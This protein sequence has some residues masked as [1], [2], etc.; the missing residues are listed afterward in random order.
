MVIVADTSPINYLALPRL[1]VRVLIP[2]AVF[3]E[4]RHPAA[5]GPVREWAGRRPSWLEILSPKNTVALPRLDLG[6][7]QAIALASETG[8]DVLLID[9]RKT[10]FRV[11]EA[12][13]AEIERKRSR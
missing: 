10:S 12:I 11:S 8:A 5:P 9:V 13:L 3:D 4:L 1:Y 7:S 6:E 2:P